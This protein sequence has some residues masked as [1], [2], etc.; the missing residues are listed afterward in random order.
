MR[1]RAH[2]EM[3][4]TKYVYFIAAYF[5][6]TRTISRDS[7]EITRRSGSR[8]VLSEILSYF[9]TAIFS[10]SPILRR[11]AITREAGRKRR[12]L[13]RVAGQRR[14]RLER[15]QPP[16]RRVLLDFAVNSL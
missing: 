6:V 9:D 8:R 12:R 4:F 15:D 13:G 1:A 16:G 5:G 14:S 10:R 7:R 3:C 2:W 11:A